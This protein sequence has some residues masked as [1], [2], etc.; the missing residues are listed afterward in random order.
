M[1]W[2]KSGRENSSMKRTRAIRRARGAEVSVQKIEWLETRRLFA[3]VVN[4]TLDE[5][6]ANATTSLR[7]AIA[8]AAANAGDDVITFD[9]T[10]FDAGGS[11]TITP[12][13]THF[14]I[15]DSG[16]EL[17]I[18]GPGRDVLTISGSSA[19]RAFFIDAGVVTISGLT[20][21]DGAGETEGGGIYTLTTLTLDDV[22]LT[23]NS[24]TG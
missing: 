16:G 10:V 22:A 17:E 11:H 15:D 5:S 24:V 23:N 6:V 1:P 12:S 21:A 9:P 18:Q 20:I 19:G 4:T 3:I 14:L 8:Q 2:E 13:P 7:E